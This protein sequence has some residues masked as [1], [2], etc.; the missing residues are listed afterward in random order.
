MASDKEIHLLETGIPL[1]DTHTLELANMDQVTAPQ[2]ARGF[3]KLLFVYGIC[4]EV[5]VDL[6]TFGFMKLIIE[7]FHLMRDMTTIGSDH[8]MVYGV[9]GMMARL[10]LVTLCGI[11]E[12]PTRSFGLT[13]ISKEDPNC[14][15]L[16]SFVYGMVVSIFFIQFFKI[17]RR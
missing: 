10:F 9:Y 12:S 4:A 1:S 6:A 11:F 13:T 16:Q 14:D 7:E 17:F 15:A 8:I 3:S 5:L 2:S